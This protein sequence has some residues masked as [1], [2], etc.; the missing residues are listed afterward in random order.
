MSEPIFFAKNGAVNLA[1]YRWGE[2]PGDRPRVLLVHG[3][4]FCGPVW[5]DVAMALA[6]E[7]AVYAFDRRGHGRSSKPSAGYDF[8]DFAGDLRAGIDHLELD[9]AYGV[10]HSAGATDLLLTAASRPAA[11]R[12]LF[13][14]EPTTMDPAQRR[15]PTP[16][17]RERAE[18]LDRVEKRR[19][20]FPSFEDVVS[21]Y[22]ERPAFLAW[23]PELL[24]LYVRTGF[25]CLDDGNVRLR[26]SPAI[27]R[28]MLGPIFDVMQNQYGLTGDSH[29]FDA[30]ASIA[31]PT[32]IAAT[33]HSPEIYQQMAVTAQRLI[34]GATKTFLAGVG[35]C[36]AQEKPSAVVDAL[37]WYWQATRR[38]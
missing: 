28:A 10:G 18:T 7:Y 23:R 17:S 32:C 2:D 31:V 6:P 5:H 34:P 8:L 29:V 14:M 21:R 26:C 13:A 24:E 37:R 3:T 22:R 19:A 20:D 36:A 35:H 27:E 12:C 33:A 1:I 4:G 38:S 11:F 30:Y 9:A 16:L 15:A 25:D